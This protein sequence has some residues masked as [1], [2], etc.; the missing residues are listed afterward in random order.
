[1][2]AVQ[3]YGNDAAVAFACSQGNLELNA[4]KPVIIRNVLHS[5]QILAG[6]CGGFTDHCVAGIQVNRKRVDELVEGSLIM[7]TALVPRIGYD[8]AARL[9]RYAVAEGVSLREANRRLGLLAEDEF[10]KLTHMS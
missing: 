8:Q 2:A 4:F 5:I 1:M 10:E 9:A 7:V 3:V 6:V